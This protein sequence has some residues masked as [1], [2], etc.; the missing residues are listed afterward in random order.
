MS[1]SEDQESNGGGMPNHHQTEINFNAPEKLAIDVE[2]FSYEHSSWDDLN[3]NSI[4]SVW[5]SGKE[6]EWG[7]E[8]W[9]LLE[10]AGEIAFDTIMERTRS[11]LYLATLAKI[12]RDFCHYAWEEPSHDSLAEIA[13][14]FGEP[15]EMSPVALGIMA[16][17]MSQ[18]DFS[19]AGD[20][21][22]IK[23]R[24][25]RVIGNVL[26]KKIFSLLLKKY[27]NEMAICER[28]IRTYPQNPDDETD[29]DNPGFVHAEQAA[30]FFVERGF[31]SEDDLY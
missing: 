22:E 25:I 27:G 10:K 9:D 31:Q 16:A 11:A 15:E 1:Q 18:E 5:V 26:R 28:L 23:Q 13:D 14:G 20:D 8:C 17:R 30:Y 2:P 3:G 7:K 29:L 19:D 24:S 21:W 12:Y 4:F 6:V